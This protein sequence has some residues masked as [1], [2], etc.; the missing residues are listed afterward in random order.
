MLRG[1]LDQSNPYAPFFVDDHPDHRTED[2]WQ[3]SMLRA[4][5]LGFVYAHLAFF[6][7]NLLL[8]A[9]FGAREPLRPTGLLFGLEGI[10][11]AFFKVVVGYVY[12]LAAILVSAFGIINGI[13]VNYWQSHRADTFFLWCSTIDLLVVTG[14]VLASR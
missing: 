6:A 7:G 11:A 12:I 2:G 9:F 4:A 5:L 8:G 1:E 14:L 3:R 10:K 13:I